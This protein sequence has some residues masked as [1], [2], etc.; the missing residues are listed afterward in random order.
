MRGPAFF[1]AK[2]GRRDAPHAAIRDGL[3]KLGFDVLDTAPLGDGIGDLQVSKGTTLIGYVEVK[4]PHGRLRPAQL[5]FAQRCFARGL[6]W[7]VAMTL[8]E[9]LEVISS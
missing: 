1:R 8:D 7:G 3:R 4:S 9:A 5:R 6:K 2:A